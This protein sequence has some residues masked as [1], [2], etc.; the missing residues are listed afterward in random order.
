MELLE[1]VRRRAMVRSF[2]SQPVDAAQLDRLL[3]GALRAPTAGNTRGTAWV[4]LEG[5]QT[6][7]YWE[8]TTDEAWRARNAEW[9][10]G[11]ARA[12]V[13]L[14]AYASP[15]AYVA[16]YAE[17]DKAD[18]GLGEGPDR[19]PVPYWFGDAAFGVMSVLLGAADAGLGACFLG[20][21]RGERA[22]AESLGV[23]A[24]W[25]LFGAVVL[26]HPDGASHRS[27]SFDRNGTAPADRIHRGSW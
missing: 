2:L 8:T 16:R 3:L 10:S 14:L 23:P 17:R 21:F 22:L 11:L 1:A 27:S 24:E 15:A 7:T 20:V 12:P 5:T 25:R 4:V 19:W 13:V 6:A 26:G 18:S 9:A